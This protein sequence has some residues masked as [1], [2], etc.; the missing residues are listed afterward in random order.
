MIRYGRVEG[1]AALPAQLHFN[2]ALAA[3][4]EVLVTTN[5]YCDRQVCLTLFLL[6]KLKI[7]L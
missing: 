6:K 3:G 7:E 2:P 1:A 4:M 5:S